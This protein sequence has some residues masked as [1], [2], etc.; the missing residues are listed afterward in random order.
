MTF[1]I[2]MDRIVMFQIH[3][4]RWIIGSINNNFIRDTLISMKNEEIVKSIKN[5]IE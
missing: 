5:Q 3:A 1:L 4:T 2:I